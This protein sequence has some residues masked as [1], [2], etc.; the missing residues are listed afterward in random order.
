[1]VKSFV[2]LPALRSYTGKYRPSRQFYPT[3]NHQANHL[4]RRK[5]LVLKLG[6]PGEQLKHCRWCEEHSAGRQTLRK[7]VREE[8]L[9][10]SADESVGPNGWW[11]KSK[12][13]IFN[14][15]IIPPWP[16]RA[17]SPTPKHVYVSSQV[18]VPSDW[19]RPSRQPRIVR[20][21]GKSVWP[22]AGRV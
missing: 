16:S 21:D 15:A 2:P 11:Q 9:T 1:M 13:T 8:H 14:R 20:G 3:G 19:N 12:L 17:P 5:A 7:R 4:G 18:G 10:Y 6:S 22:G